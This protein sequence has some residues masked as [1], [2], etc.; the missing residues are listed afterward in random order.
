[1]SGGLPAAKDLAQDAFWQTDALPTWIDIR[2]L[3]NGHY[4]TMVHF[5]SP[6]SDREMHIN[7]TA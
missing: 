3:P 6:S 5:Y 4:A 7:M 1:M 2:E